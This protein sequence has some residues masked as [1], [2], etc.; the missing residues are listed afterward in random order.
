[1]SIL[2]IAPENHDFDGLNE[3]SSDLQRLDA[4]FAVLLKSSYGE[5]LNTWKLKLK[6]SQQTYFE[7]LLLETGLVVDDSGDAE[8]THFKLTSKATVLLNKYGSY[9]NFISQVEKEETIQRTKAE[10]RE[11]LELQQLRTN[12]KIL[13]DQHLDYLKDRKRFIR[14]EWALWIGI[15]LSLIAILISTSSKK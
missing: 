2:N 5:Y 1:M 10:E 14:N 7:S 4:F 8:Q 13:T 9:S 11:N 15:L 12:V 3:N 6:Y